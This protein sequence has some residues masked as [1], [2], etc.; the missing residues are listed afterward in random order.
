MKLLSKVVWS[1]GM[2]LGPHHFQAQNRYFEDSVHFA[3]ASLWD[4]GYGFISLQMDDQAIRNGAVAILNARGI[5]SDGL[6]FEMPACDQ[7]PNA[8]HVSEH[9]PL[10]SDAVTVYLAIPSLTDDGPNCDLQTNAASPTSRFIGALKTL[11]DENTGRDDKPIHL[12]RKNIQL[13]IEGEAIEDLLTLPVARVIRA[14]GGSFTFDPSFI[15][16]CTKL[17]AS[18]RLVTIARSLVGIL[19]EKSSAIS[20]RQQQSQGRFRAGMSSTEVSEF[21][22][23]HAINS[24]LSGLRHFLLSKHGH[25]EELY[26]E[27]LRLGGALC[28]FG[29]QSHPRSLPL[30]NHN[31]LGT[32]F[33]ALEDHIRRHLEIVVPTQAISIPLSPTANYFYKGEVKDSRCVDRSRWIFGIHSPIGEADLIMKAPQLVKICSAK[34]VP[35]LVRRALPGLELSHLPVAP[36]AISPRYDT[37]YFAVSKAGPCWDHIVQSREIG[38]YV[39]GEFHEPEIQ[40]TVILDK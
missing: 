23:L 20:E 9:F 8:R 16:P 12:G 24:S 5:F 29:L 17:H 27:M 31:D 1:E 21:W 13:L 38:I 15:P 40:L 37:Q 22:F 34:F 26:L 18:E 28:T 6:P 30:Y 10:S 32:C 39:P 36:T 4:I 11:P 14:A 35:E 3:I 25:P 33:D 2:Y 19:E 7:L